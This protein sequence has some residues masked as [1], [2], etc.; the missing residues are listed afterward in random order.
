MNGLFDADCLALKIL[1]VEPAGDDL[2]V[3]DLEQRHPADLEGL[4]VPAAT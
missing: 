4:P 2:T 1:H 3:T